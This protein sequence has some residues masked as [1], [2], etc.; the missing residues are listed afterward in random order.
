M[1]DRGIIFLNRTLCH[2][3]V[4]HHEILP[5]ATSERRIVLFCVGRGF[6][7]ARADARDPSLGLLVVDGQ[8]SGQDESNE[9]TDPI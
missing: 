1:V 8:R 5:I 9:G 7:L 4:Q 2:S 3:H 6:V